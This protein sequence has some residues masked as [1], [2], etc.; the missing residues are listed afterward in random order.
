MVGATYSRGIAEDRMAA[1]SLTGGQT[2]K[3]V[4][5]GVFVAAAIVLAAD[6][7]PAGGQATPNSSAAF[8]TIET[9]GPPPKSDGGAN[10]E[11]TV[12]DVIMAEHADSFRISPDS[13]WVVWVKHAVDTDKDGGVSNLILSSLTE[14]KEIELTRGADTNSSPKW[15]RD[16]RLIAFISSRPLPKPPK[17]VSGK[18]S[19][20]QI[21]LINP[22]GGE[23]WPLTHS[24]RGVRGFDWLS[25]DTILVAAEED[26]SLYERK[27]VEGKDNSRV[28]D[29]AF[30]TPPVRLFR[31]DARTGQVTRLTHN[32]D[33]IDSL[34]VSP[35]GRKVVVRHARSLSYEFDQKVPPIAILHD[36]QT[37]E[38]K[39]LFTDGRILPG[40]VW[41]APSS[42]G[43]YVTSAYSTDPVYRTATVEQLYYYDL[44]KDRTVKVDLGWENEMGGGFAVT[45]N[46]FVALLAAGSRYK[47]VRYT[48]EGEGWTKA[49]VEGEHANNLFAL[50]LGKD[51]QTLVYHSSTA[52][53]PDQWYRAKLQGPSISNAVPVTELNPGFAKKPAAKSEVIR[54]KGALDEEVEGILYYPQKFEPGKKYPLV[55][56]IHGGPTGA[57]MDAWSQS[58]AYPV[59]LY[60]QRGALVFR[61]NYHGSGNYGLKWVESIGHGKYYDL[62]VPDIEKGV[63]DLIARGL[64]DPEKLGVLGWSNGGILT[65]A[66]VVTN[67]RF[68]VASAGAADVEWI[69]D[70]SNVVFGASFDNYYFGKAPIDDPELYIRKSPLFKMKGVQ[71]PLLLFHGSE[72]FQVPPSQSWEAFR[73]LQQLGKT[74]KYVIFPGE[75]H[76]PQKLSHQRRKVEE[77]LG[78]FDRYLFKPGQAGNEAFK[79][80]S[81]LGQQLKRRAIKRAGLRYG[82]ELKSILVPETVKYQGLEIGRF[83]VT[84]A[85]FAAF[86]KNYKFEAGTENY[87]ASGITFENAQA[88]CAW[89]TETTGESY[90]LGTETEMEAIYK[91]A[92]GGENTLDY[93]AGYSPNPEDTARLQTKIRELG[94]QS[95]LLREVGSFK[96]VG[97]GELVFDLGGNVAE[98]VVSKNGAGKALGGSADRPADSKQLEAAPDP[99]Y[100]GFRVVKAPKI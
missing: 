43:F 21:W 51:G 37:G 3:K 41:W 28:V 6:L 45:P 92:K 80:D 89:L 99:A 97:E 44:A 8:K 61:P 58:W 24:E 26:P 53:R 16:G 42:D 59:N 75:P 83:E 1:K 47:A 29:D 57:D 54:W 13:Q 50:E 74:V 68:K 70:W 81:P 67:T 72:D 76:G 71:T 34:E 86:D 87:P 7:H 95:P 90:R 23:P 63:D 22:F 9:S 73:N 10:R 12:D 4:L 18:P 40:R 19:P 49:W 52:S 5:A 17:D 56:M 93:W 39:Q 15:S 96:G 20:T 91:S 36:L 46:G 66:L 65:D 2:M 94:G 11:W 48:R 88:Y 84:H 31:V 14:K 78:W 38:E 60:T 64:T 82:F 30:H 27:L 32:D 79:D 85:Q 55:V 77:E 62:E 69:S 100:V 35:D 33:W 98:W 25:A